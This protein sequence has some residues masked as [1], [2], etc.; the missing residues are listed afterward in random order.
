MDRQAAKYPDAY[1]IEGPTKRNLI[2][3]S[4]DDGPSDYTTELLKTLN[5]HGV[6]ATFFWL[7]S[8]VEK[9]PEIVKAA[10]AQG[11][12][13]GNHT[14]SHPHCRNLSPDDF[15]T[16]EVELAQTVMQRVV[17]FAPVLFRPTYGEL[18]DQQI[19]FLKKKRMK[20]I[21]WSID[22]KDWS[23]SDDQDTSQNIVDTV[24]AHA[25]PEAIVLM[26]DGVFGQ[27]DNTIRAVDALV[28]LLKAR[29]YEFVTIDRL[30]DVES[31][32]AQ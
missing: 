30:L 13:I 6:A 7:G 11:H 24:M 14:Y 18:N 17:G 31:K 21:G 29:G 15:W 25:H 3:L 5:K 27:G 19:E 32:P 1:F 20:T 2:A 22:P 10:V 9:H 8:N 28:P 16:A 26:H 4:F 23:M 12:T